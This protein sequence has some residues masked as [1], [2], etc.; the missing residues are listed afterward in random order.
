[1]APHPV[2]AGAPLLVAHRGGA[3]LAP[4]N[5]LA[6]FSN[7][8]GIWGADMIEFDVHA[9]RDGHCV[10]I[11]DATVDRTTD[12]A[13]AVA[14]LTLAELKQLDAG[15]RFTTDRGATFPFRHRGVTIPTIDDVLDLLP[16]MRF[17]VEVKNG[18]AQEPLFAAITSR[19]AEA[20]VI[21]AGMHERDRTMFA[22]YA[23]PVSSSTEALRR[24]YIGHRLRLG[25]LFRPR[26]D[27]V[28]V[29]ETW[30]GRR[31]VTPRFVRDL[32]RCGI[33]VHV[34]TVDDP[35]DMH[36][37]LDWGVEG[38]VTDRPDVLGHVLRERG[39]RAAGPTGDNRGTAGT[40]G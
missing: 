32:R 2:L 34:W 11:H 30:E 17:T 8:A 6:A 39:V 10:V 3:G 7:G 20:R 14:A 13:G 29:P 33:P 15:Y 28:Q 35:R 12:G 1:M 36:R 21:A 4:E 27:V 9:S 24:F 38:L 40:G 22:G 19:R 37:L 18:A 23:G 26:A 16:T 31:V 5:T 25:R